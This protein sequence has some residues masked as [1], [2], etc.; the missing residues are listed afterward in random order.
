M[1]AIFKC[2]NCGA[3]S[4][5]LDYNVVRMGSKCFLCGWWNSIPGFLENFY[6]ETV[7]KVVRKELAWLDRATDR[8]GRDLRADIALVDLIIEKA[9]EEAV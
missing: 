1:N 3:E 9:I 4:Q 7:G 2:S 5:V 8:Q 6:G